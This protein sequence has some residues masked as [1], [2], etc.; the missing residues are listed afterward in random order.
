MWS[1][2]IDTDRVDII[3]HHDP[4]TLEQMQAEVD[5]YIQI[6]PAHTLGPLTAAFANEDCLDKFGPNHVAGDM[7][8][9]YWTM[10]PPL[11]PVLIVGQDPA[12]ENDQAQLADEVIARARLVADEAG[13]PVAWRDPRVD[14]DTPPS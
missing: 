7:L 4:L 10:A 14:L 13:V 11:G 5:G 3:E 12:R 1:L 8:G 2:L 9:G 6:L